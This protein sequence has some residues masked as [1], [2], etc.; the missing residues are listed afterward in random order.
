MRIYLFTLLV[1]VGLIAWIA[2]PSQQPAERINGACIV[3]PPRPIDASAFEEIKQV[4]AEWVA[5]IPYG[6]SRAGIPDVSYD[7]S[8]QWWGEHTDGNCMMIQYAKEN[9]LKVMCKPHVWVRG[10]GWA[11]DF[12]L[13]T[14]EEWKTWENDYTKYILN[15]AIK[16]DSMDVELFCIG[17]EYRIPA[18]ERP[19]FWRSLIDKVREVYAGKVTYAANWDNYENI[20]WWDAVDYIGVD[21][22]FPLAEGDHPKADAIK[23][24]WEPIKKNMSA[25]S[26]KWEKPILFT[27][28]GFQSIN[29]ATGNHWEVDKSTVSSNPTLQ[30]DAYEA[31]FQ[32]FENE[33]WFAGGFFWKWHFTMRT[34]DWYQKE[35][36]PQNKPASEVIAQWYGKD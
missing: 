30:A 27:E 16:A 6:F 34:G 9:G 12:D 5:V 31:T 3:N 19:A 23:S 36:T 1:V 10:Q 17:T 26:K 15:H 35:W 24:G 20:T 32:A 11:G 29:G 33:E 14:E 7:H 4:N 22:Y 13:N 21:A 18:R 25:F 2:I 8:R 28:Y